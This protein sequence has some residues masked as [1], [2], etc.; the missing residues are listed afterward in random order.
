MPAS[1]V[2][3]AA[4]DDLRRRV[5]AHLARQRTQV[6]ALL[7]LRQ[8]LQGSLFVRYGECGKAACACREGRRHGPYYVFSARA[9]G[10]GSFRYLDASRARQAREQVARY[11]E[12]RQGLAALQRV[13]VEL[14]ALLRRYQQRQL[15]RTAKAISARVRA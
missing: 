12:F 5:R 15:R 14:V 11:R 8:Q 7:R 9:A 3:A 4:D 6:A 2:S 13:N 10:R 1:L